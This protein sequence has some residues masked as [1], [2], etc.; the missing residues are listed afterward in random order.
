MIDFEWKRPKQ[1]KNHN[2]RI[3][4]QCLLEKKN[5]KKMISSRKKRP[6]SRITSKMEPNCLNSYTKTLKEKS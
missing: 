4:K 1:K 5:M 3:E 6:P 2:I